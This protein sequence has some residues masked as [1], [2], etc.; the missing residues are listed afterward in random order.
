[1]DAL[2]KLYIRVTN[3]P[4]PDILVVTTITD[5]NFESPV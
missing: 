1:M 5:V 3:T 4:S 2:S